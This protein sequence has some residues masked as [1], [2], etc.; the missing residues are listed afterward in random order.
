[1]GKVDHNG[2][3][4]LLGDMS[5]RIFLLLL[6]HTERSD[7]RAV[8]KNLKLEHLGEV[9]IPECLAYLDNG[10]VYVGSRLGDSQLI[11]LNTE[12]DENGSY[13]DTLDTFTNLGPIVDMVV[14]DLEKQGQG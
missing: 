12:P 5:G 4:Y 9:T 3:R 14:V 7:N 6:E 10:V 2:S 8:V 11:K 1:Y 13:I